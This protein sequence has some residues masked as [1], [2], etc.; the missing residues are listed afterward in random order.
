MAAKQPFKGFKGEIFPLLCL[1]R[2][3]NRPAEQKTKTDFQ[4]SGICKI[5]CSEWAVK[6]PMCDDEPTRSIGFGITL[7]PTS[8]F[9]KKSCLELASRLD[10]LLWRWRRA[11]KR[12]QGSAE[13]RQRLECAQ[14]SQHRYP[15]AKREQR[16]AEGM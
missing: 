7:W 13:W 4:I 14:G 8:V 2:P 10:F 11:V 16:G 9:S 12:R 6:S 5:I 3:P 1:R 15:R